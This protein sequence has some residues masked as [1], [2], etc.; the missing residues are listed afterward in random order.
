MTLVLQI[1]FALLNWEN[2]FLG[3]TLPA[4][5]RAGSMYRPSKNELSTSYLLEVCLNILNYPTLILNEF[6]HPLKF[7]QTIKTKV[8]LAPCH[9]ESFRNFWSPGSQT[10]NW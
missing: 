2:L 5:I 9:L 7:E 8:G 10:N 6:G 3:T 4:A 1:F